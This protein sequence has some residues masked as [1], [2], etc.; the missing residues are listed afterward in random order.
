MSR[1]QEIFVELFKESKYSAKQISAWS[2]VHESTLSRFINNKTDM[3]AGDFFK[4][5]ASLPKDFQKQFWDRF[6]DSK[7]DW[8]SLL[9][10][11]SSKDLKEICNLIGDLL[12]D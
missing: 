10:S 6:H 4:L 11:A 7:D 12:S 2:G 8:Q 1:H 5:L 3:K 9:L